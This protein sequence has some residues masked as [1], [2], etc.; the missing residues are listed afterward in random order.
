MK[1]YDFIVTLNSQDYL[2]GTVFDEDFAT[3]VCSISDQVYPE[4]KLRYEERDL[5]QPPRTLDVPKFDA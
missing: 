5:E 3:F 4:F 1:V 2:L